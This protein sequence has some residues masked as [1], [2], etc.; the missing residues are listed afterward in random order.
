MD[1]PLSMTSINNEDI[2][3]FMLNKSRKSRFCSTSQIKLMLFPFLEKKKC[4][5]SKMIFFFGSRWWEWNKTRFESDVGTHV[6]NPYERRRKTKIQLSTAHWSSSSMVHLDLDLPHICYWLVQL[7]FVA[8][9]PLVDIEDNHLI[10]DRPKV[11]AFSAFVF[12]L[13]SP[14]RFLYSFLSFFVNLRIDLWLSSD[15]MR[16]CFYL[17]FWCCWSS[18]SICLSDRCETKKRQKPLN[19]DIPLI[20]SS[21][22]D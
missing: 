1:R 8:S 14:P 5:E 12:A 22:D 19:I 16:I 4:N 7:M 6:S 17:T 21:I 10:S 15:D 20:F 18:R 3:Y 2:F 13:V 9:V 11:D